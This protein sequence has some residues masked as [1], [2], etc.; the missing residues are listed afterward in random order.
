M[1]G[2]IMAECPSLPEK[3]REKTGEGG[4]VFTK[5]GKAS[6]VDKRKGL[7]QQGLEL[8]RSTLH[9]QK[10][11]TMINRPTPESKSYS[12]CPASSSAEFFRDMETPQMRT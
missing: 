6:I 8:R 11:A 5:V 4:R 7:G 3:M 10:E 12:N 2:H 1:L 9:H